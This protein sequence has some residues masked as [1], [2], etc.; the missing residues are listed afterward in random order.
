M[1]DAEI[2]ETWCFPPRSSELHR[3]S[4]ILTPRLTISRSFLG[5]EKEEVF[6]EDGMLNAGTQL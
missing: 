3:I 4:G 1:S 5:K 2:K 6:Q